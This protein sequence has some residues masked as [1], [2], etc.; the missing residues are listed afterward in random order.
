MVSLAHGHAEDRLGLER[1]DRVAVKL[2]FSQENVYRF[3]SKRLIGD[4]ILYYYGYR[5]YDTANQK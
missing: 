5:F 3:S 1:I 2:P 4:P